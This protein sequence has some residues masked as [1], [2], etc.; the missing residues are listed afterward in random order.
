MIDLTADSVVAA[1]GFFGTA[2]TCVLAVRS[3]QKIINAKLDL[4]D[5]L[6]DSR[7]LQI[8]A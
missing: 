8:D 1:I 3:N 6:N 5:K 4:S 2:M 7:F